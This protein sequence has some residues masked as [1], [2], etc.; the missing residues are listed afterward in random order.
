M[1]NALNEA[2]REIE[3]LL[4]F[5]HNGRISA[6]DRAR[7]EI[8]L[9][10]NAELRRRL[11]LIAEESEAAIVLNEA[12]GAP[13][14]RALDA[15][16][17]KIEAEPKRI[18]QQ[19]GA[20]RRG[21]ME[22]LGGLIAALSPK[23]L[24]Y[25]S[26][27]AIA[28]IAAQGVVLTGVVPG[29]GPGSQNYQTASAPA[30]SDGTFVLISFAPEA[31]AVAIADLLKSV[32]ASIVEGPRASGLYRVRIGDKALP[33]PESERIVARLQAAKDVVALVAPDQ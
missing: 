25:A 4:P 26:A 30:A 9:G 15:L 13:S 14:P 32:G 3:D 2:D 17:A 12:A 16:M 27:A 10:T 29:S 7:V 18:A 28:V 21:L 24:A 33:R 1:I 6:A 23:T 5:Y 20:V 11:D 22:R 8:A 31:K 19:V